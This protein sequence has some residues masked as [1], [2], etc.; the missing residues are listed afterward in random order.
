MKVA[1][2]NKVSAIAYYALRHEKVSSL[3]FV[4]HANRA[5]ATIFQ[6]Q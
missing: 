2:A 4:G 6:F 5:T 1:I 3:T